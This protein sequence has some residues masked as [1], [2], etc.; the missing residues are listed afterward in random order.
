[1]RLFGVWWCVSV[2]CSVDDVHLVVGCVDIFSTEG[3]ILAQDERW[4]R[5]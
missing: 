5:A 2:E 3:L 1:M 4:R